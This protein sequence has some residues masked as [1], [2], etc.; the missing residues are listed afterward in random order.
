[1]KVQPGEHVVVV[2]GGI[3]GAMC[4]WYLQQAGCRITIVDREGF[5][6]ACS[7]ANCGY[8]SPSHVLPLC[9]PGA[10]SKTMKTMFSANS[11]IKIKPRLSI[12]LARWM[13]NFAWQCNQKKMMASAAARHAILQSSKLEYQRLIDQHQLD[14]EWQEVGLLFVFDHKKEFEAFEKTDSTIQKHFGVKATP[15]DGEQL[16][17]LEPAIKPGFGGGWH[18]EGD[19]HLRPDRLM[20]QLK[21]KLVAGGATILEHQNIDSIENRGGIAHAVNSAEESIEGDH[22]VIATGAMTPM[23]NRWLGL[24]IPIQPGKGYSLT[25]P[26]P[27]RMPK[28]P[29]IFEDSHVAITPMQSKYRIGSTMEFVGYDTSINED[30][31]KL[32]RT[33]AEKYL[34]EPYCDPIEETWFGWRP[35]TWD[36]RPIIDR[37]PSMKNVWIAAG[38]NMLGLSMGAGTGRLVKELMLGEPTHIDANPFSVSRFQ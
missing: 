6:A 10:I 4:S 27:A 12:S 26:K 23:L 5:G 15:Y 11:P 28:I 34:H 22:I 30:R 19:C 9:Q 1:M 35:M 38:H 37:S 31:I 21:E 18:Y 13:W 16:V 17:E 25:M 8:V 24:Q 3:I 32:L 36:G 2:G 14:C 7:H 20:S 33:A 29:I